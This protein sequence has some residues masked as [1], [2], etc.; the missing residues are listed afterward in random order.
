MVTFIYIV[1]FSLQPYGVNDVIGCYID[2][3][4]GVVQWAK[5][6]QPLGEAY[7]IPEETL[8]SAF[9]PTS[10]LKDSTLDFNFGDRPFAYP[11]PVNQI[12]IFIINMQITSIHL[13]QRCVYMSVTFVIRL[14][15]GPFEMLNCIAILSYT[16]GTITFVSFT[17]ERYYCVIGKTLAF[18]SFRLIV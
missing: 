13:P 8:R 17:C 4:T 16:I 11:P 12:F 6:G 15:K 7:T 10:S 5:N 2:L 1:S 14:S 18:S 3:D 9:Y